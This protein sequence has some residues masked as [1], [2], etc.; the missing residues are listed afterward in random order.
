[1]PEIDTLSRNRR[2]VLKSSLATL[3]GGLPEM[4]RGD[5]QVREGPRATLRLVNAELRSN[6]AEP[7]TIRLQ[8]IRRSRQ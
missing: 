5:G 2:N 4:P 6:T 8:G 3:A 7:N 1:V